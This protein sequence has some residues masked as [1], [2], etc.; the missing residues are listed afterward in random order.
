MKVKVKD[1]D[2]DRGRVRVSVDGSVR[3][4]AEALMILPH[5]PARQI[6]LVSMDID[7]LNGEIAVER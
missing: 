1:R 4:Q 6:P 5:T 3:S 7:T 2:R